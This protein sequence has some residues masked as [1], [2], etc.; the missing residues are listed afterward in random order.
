MASKI[1]EFLGDMSLT[2]FSDFYASKKEGVVVVIACCLGV[3]EGVDMW[4]P[5]ECNGFDPRLHF[6]FFV[7]L[8]CWFLYVLC[9]GVVVN[10]LLI[11]LYS[12]LFV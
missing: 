12:L 6:F 3:E 5:D 7:R 4:F 11:P 2:R 10:V 8:V 1:L 9:A